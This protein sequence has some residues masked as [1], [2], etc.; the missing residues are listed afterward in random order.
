MPIEND[1]RFRSI[2][3]CA[4]E[5]CMAARAVARPT[6]YP[7]VRG[8]TR[9]VQPPTLACKGLSPRARGNL[10]GAVVLREGAGSIPACAGE[11]S[12]SIRWAVKSRVYP[13]V[14]GGTSPRRSRRPLR[15]GLSPRAR[16][17]QF[18]S[19]SGELHGG[20]IPA[21]AGEPLMGL[22]CE[23][24]TAVYPRVRGG[25]GH[26]PWPHFEMY[27]LSPRARGNPEWRAAGLPV[28]GLPAPA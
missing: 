6:V 5:P 25:T 28:A 23:L 11:P 10:Q 27:G 8:G 14:R 7:R 21:C 18:G 1:Y 13:R 19:D 3:A 2:P 16:G 22:A 9:G 24:V 20:S 26:A 4:G 15:E 12:S 17:N